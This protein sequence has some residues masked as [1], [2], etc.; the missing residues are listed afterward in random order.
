MSGG[1]RSN[2]GRVLFDA[3]GSST[4][5]NWWQ[6]LVYGWRATTPSHSK[7]LPSPS[8]SPSSLSSPSSA[9]AAEEELQCF[10]RAELDALV[11][12]R[13]S[14]DVHKNNREL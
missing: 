6:R 11:I 1:G 2:T 14:H 10:T 7:D 12:E 9:Y 8:P 3:D 4:V 5:S 13:V